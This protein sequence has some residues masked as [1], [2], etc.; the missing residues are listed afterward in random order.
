MNSSL[1]YAA[2]EFA[3]CVF[4]KH[5]WTRINTLHFW[6]LT[7]SHS[8]VKY[9]PTELLS[10]R[11]S[12]EKRSCHKDQRG[13]LDSG[14]A[15]PEP[16]HCTSHRA[17][18]KKPGAGLPLEKKKQKQKRAIRQ[19]RD[20][21]P[22]HM[23]TKL[24]LSSIKSKSQFM[25]PAVCAVC[26]VYAASAAMLQSCSMHDCVQTVHKGSR[27]SHTP[28]DVWKTMGRITLTVNCTASL[29]HHYFL[30]S[31]WL[32]EPWTDWL[33]T[34]TG[35]AVHTANTEVKDELAVRLH[36][37]MCRWQR[38]SLLLAWKK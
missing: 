27:Q 34:Q 8:A 10:L 4:D 26:A 12:S 6:E 28:V 9:S 37:H 14:P 11:Q 17:R 36:V 24:Y 2:A 38:G 23:E 5:C 16:W 30:K 20:R 33:C 18:S 13:P 32:Q 19:T 25:R 7:G 15:A 3:H 31:L 1:T 21:N 29:P 35:R 22:S